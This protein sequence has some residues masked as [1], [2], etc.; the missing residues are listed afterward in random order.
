MAYASTHNVPHYLF[1][2]SRYNSQRRHHQQEGMY[3][4]ESFVGLASAE[5]FI[6][7]VIDDDGGVVV[8]FVKDRF[9]EIHYDDMGYNLRFLSAAC[10]FHHMCAKEGGDG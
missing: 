9:I 7:D 5:A 4:L 3:R 2:L 6:L 10:L 8:D 1:L